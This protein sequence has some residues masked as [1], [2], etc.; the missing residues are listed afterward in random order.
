MALHK[1]VKLTEVNP[2]FAELPKSDVLDD[3][4][5]YMLEVYIDDYISFA[6]PRI[7]DQLHHVANAVMI[8]THDVFPPDKDDGEYLIYLKRIL[9]R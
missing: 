7:R 5:N 4:F 6:I 3:P 2:D 1:F 9:K 8:G